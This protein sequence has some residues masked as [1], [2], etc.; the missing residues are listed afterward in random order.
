MIVV[1]V[2]V[3]VVNALT[4]VVFKQGYRSEVKNEIKVKC[5]RLTDR[6]TE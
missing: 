2:I 3:V 1:V 4:V 5:D 6:P